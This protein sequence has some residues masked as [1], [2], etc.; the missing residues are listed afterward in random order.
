VPAARR[1]AGGPD[2]EPPDL[3]EDDRRWM[4]EALAEAAAAGRRG[5][6]P[7]GTVIV[8]G[9]RLLARAGN[10]SIE[11]NDPTAHAEVL[12]IRA[13]AAAAR[14]YRLVGTTLYVT[15]EPCA[16]C[17]GAALH[18]RIARLVY[19]CADP[20]AGAAGSVVDLARQR[21]LNH[22]IEVTGGVSAEASRVLLRDFFRTRR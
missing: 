20:K 7:V 15:V 3:A 5:E 2:R 9:P 11:R 18:A 21:R 14:S 12:A 1:R 13:A 16:M 6:V 19:G 17:M 8:A 10:A 22:H 4:S